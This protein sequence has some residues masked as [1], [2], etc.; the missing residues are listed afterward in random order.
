MK[1]FKIELTDVGYDDYSGAVVAANTLS[2][3]KDLCEYGND[4][5]DSDTHTY[6]VETRF[7]REDSF[8]RNNHQKYYIKEIGTTNKYKEPTIIISSFCGG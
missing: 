3:V 7:K 4:I 8:N 5:Y 6:I 2:E 1:L